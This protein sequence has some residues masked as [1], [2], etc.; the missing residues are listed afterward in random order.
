MA[1]K[2]Y[3]GR[4]P[5]CDAEIVRHDRRRYVFCPSCGGFLNVPPYDKEE[6]DV[7]VH[8]VQ[9]EE[10]GTWQEM[11][12]W[13]YA[14]LYANIYLK[15]REGVMKAKERVDLCPSC[16]VGRIKRTVFQGLNEWLHCEHCGQHLSVPGDMDKP[17]GLIQVKVGAEVQVPDWARYEPP[18]G[19]RQSL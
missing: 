7:S 9:F 10:G 3:K 6:E 16:R 19:I 5:K 12:I 4:C 15:A 17:I 8:L 18:V 2:A 1:W 11:A 13:E 14:R